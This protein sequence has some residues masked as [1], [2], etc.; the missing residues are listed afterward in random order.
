MVMSLMSGFKFPLGSPLRSGPK[1][2]AFSDPLE[3]GGRSSSAK[4]ALD[5]EHKG[6]GHAQDGEAGLAG[7]RGRGLSENWAGR[8]LAGTWED[9]TRIPKT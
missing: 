4:Q 1:K 3:N 2:M 7:P 6:A 8:T 9:W 5:V